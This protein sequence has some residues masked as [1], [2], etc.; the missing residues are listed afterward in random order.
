MGRRPLMGFLNR[1][2]ITCW[3][4]V[5]AFATMS[6]NVNTPLSVSKASPHSMA[7]CRGCIPSSAMVLSLNT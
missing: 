1:L 5:G 2:M 3:R 6:I 7:K 4:F